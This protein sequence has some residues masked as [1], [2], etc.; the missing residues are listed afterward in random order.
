MSFA[1]SA[2]CASNLTFTLP[3]ADGSSGQV[4]K[5]DGSCNLGL[6]VLTHQE[7]QRVSLR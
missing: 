5:T 7:P 4:I 2:L 3:A 6:L 1:S